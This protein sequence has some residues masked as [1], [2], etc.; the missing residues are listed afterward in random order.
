MG[1]SLTENDTYLYVKLEGEILSPEA[2]G[3]TIAKV[4]NIC[5]EKNKHALVHRITETKQPASM[6]DFYGFSQY[7]EKHWPR[8]QKVAIVYPESMI[9]GIMDF[10][11]I[12]SQNRG[13]NVK[14]FS[15]LK[16][17]ESWIQ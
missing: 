2:I 8:S 11:E 5:T 6:T 10:F 13:I 9:K 14:L 7:L 12:A 17:A 15:S 4:T 16:D 3:E 1:V